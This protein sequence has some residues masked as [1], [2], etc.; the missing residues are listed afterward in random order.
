MQGWLA[1]LYDV[2]G[3]TAAARHARDESRR[4]SATVANRTELPQDVVDEA[5]LAIGLR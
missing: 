2:L 4:L 5:R 3:D 1:R